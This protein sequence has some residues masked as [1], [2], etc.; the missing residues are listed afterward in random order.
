M[1]AEQKV[2]LWSM[3]VSGMVA[4]QAHPRNGV[5]DVGEM[6]LDFFGAVADR[7]VAMAELREALWRTSGVPR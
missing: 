6:K 2:V 3:F 5:G 1:D 7:M 4:M